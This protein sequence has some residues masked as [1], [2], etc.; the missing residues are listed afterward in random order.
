MPSPDIHQP[1]CRALQSCAGRTL[2]GGAYRLVSPGFQSRSCSWAS[3]F[4]WKS[5]AGVSSFVWNPAAFFSLPGKEAGDM[6]GA[7]VGGTRGRAVNHGASLGVTS[8]PAQSPSLPA[9][10]QTPSLVNQSSFPA[11]GK[12]TWRENQILIC[13][14]KEW[15][16]IFATRQWCYA[17]D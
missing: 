3:F 15:T 16:H 11:K 10:T 17:G 6:L 7:G 5:L 14:Q 1:L 8:S 2:L 4:C 12:I 13:S 9:L